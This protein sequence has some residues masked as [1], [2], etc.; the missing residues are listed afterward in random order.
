[1]RSLI[2]ATVAALA[3]ASVVPAFAYQT[4]GSGHSRP[5][6]IH[7]LAHRCHARGRGCHAQTYQ[8]GGSHGDDPPTESRRG[9]ITSHQ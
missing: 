5:G 8:L 3:L 6:I 4:G 2:I 1:M 9:R 7:P